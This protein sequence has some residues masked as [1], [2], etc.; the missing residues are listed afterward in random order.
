MILFYYALITQLG[1]QQ[2]IRA[3]SLSRR[4]YRFHIYTFLRCFAR[5]IED[6]YTIRG[7]HHDAKDGWPL[8]WRRRLSIFLR[9]PNSGNTARRDLL[10]DI[11]VLYRCWLIDF[12]VIA[13]FI[14]LHFRRDIKARLAVGRDD[15]DIPRATIMHLIEPI[16]RLT[17][18]HAAGIFSPAAQKD[19]YFWGDHWSFQLNHERRRH[20]WLFL[21]IIWLSTTLLIPRYREKN[22][23]G[24]IFYDD[25]F[26][27]FKLHLIDAARALRWWIFWND[28][29][30]STELQPPK[31]RWYA[32]FISSPSSDD[33]SRR[34]LTFR[35]AP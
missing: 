1:A 9:S 19:C 34:R 32:A 27:Y 33:L 17:S 12:K 28:F 29:A 25:W 30:S 23:R 2:I 35:L 31:R 7:Q 8:Y 15:D 4:H 20:T 11:F 14:W 6:A 5:S 3:S 21:I 26:C 24:I 22:D 16:D 10:G 18:R 13:C